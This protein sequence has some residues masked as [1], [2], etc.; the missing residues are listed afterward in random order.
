VARSLSARAEF[1]GLELEDWGL[2]LAWAIVMRLIGDRVH[3][4]FV[5]LLPVSA[6]LAYGSSLVLIVVI[7]WAKAGKPRGFLISWLQHHLRPRAHSA[8]FGQLDQAYLID[9]ES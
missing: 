6:L 9:D 4:V 2:V 8:R 7:R 5:G 3:R 1:L